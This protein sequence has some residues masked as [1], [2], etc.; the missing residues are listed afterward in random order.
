VPLEL[1]SR[2]G[3]V[4]REFQWDVTVMKQTDTTPDGGRDGDPQSATSEARVFG[5]Y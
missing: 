1:Y 4:E 5:W 2:A 3:Q